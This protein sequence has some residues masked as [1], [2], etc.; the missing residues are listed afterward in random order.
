M[1]LHIESEAE[2]NINRFSWVALS[3][4]SDLFIKLCELT[5]E[6][7]DFRGKMYHFKSFVTNKSLKTIV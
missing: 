1:N 5:F 7:G 2:Y 6:E 4:F 3:L